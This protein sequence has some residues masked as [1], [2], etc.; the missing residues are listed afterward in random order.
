MKERINLL[1]NRKE[2]CILIKSAFTPDFCDQIIAGKKA[3]FKKA[4]THYPTSYRNNERQLTD[5]ED[6]SNRLFSEIKNHIPT[7]IEVEG[8]AEVEQGAWMIDYLN[9][10][11]RICRY[12]PGQYFHKHLDGVHFVSESQQSKLT[13]MI[14]L[15]G[16]EDFTG[17]KTLFFNSK[18][19]DTI[20]GSYEAKKGDLIIFDHNLWH[21]GAVVLKGEKYILRSDIIYR[22]I[23]KK[24]KTKEMFCGEGHL[25]YIWT[26]T[27]WKDWLLT[28][29]RD[30]KIKIWSKQ[31]FKEGELLGHE[32]SILNVFAFDEKTILSSSRDGAIKIWDYSKNNQF[33]LEH[34]EIYGDG[35]VLAICKIDDHTFFSGGADGQLNRIKITGEQVNTIQAHNEWIWGI[36]KITPNYFATISEDG[37]LKIWDIKQQKMIANWQE[38]IPINSIS[39]EN[40]WIYIG[41]FDGSI[42]IFDFD[43]NLKKI[44]LVKQE[45]CHLGIIR[46]LLVTNKYLYSAS[47][48][49]TAKIWNKATLKSVETFTHKNFVQD[50]AIFDDGL[51]TVSYDGE[52]KRNLI[53]K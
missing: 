33:S 38:N 34:S 29:G 49:C 20:I 3:S 8:I 19:D 17:G 6:F 36:A 11:I 2:H 18:K 16:S 28:S 5:D 27:V 25:G 12:L 53:K 22:K 35:A 31:G 9:P 26:A 39:V 45:K 46:R 41:R 52:I 40:S 50:L 43:Q 37:S 14:Y 4:I 1:P 7:T 44:K 13:F 15:N 21:S 24:H 30:K 32:S 42:L 48:D 23:G 51:I 10:R 47:E